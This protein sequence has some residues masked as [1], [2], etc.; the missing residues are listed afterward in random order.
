MYIVA[1][2]HLDIFRFV[3]ICVLECD[4]FNPN[5]NSFFTIR[6]QLISMNIIFP[7][8]D[9]THLKHFFPLN[10]HSMIMVKPMEDVWF[11]GHWVFC[12][13]DKCSMMGGCLM[14]GL[15]TLIKQK[16]KSFQLVKKK[17]I[18]R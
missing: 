11:I 13:L 18:F 6:K 9:Q 8:H 2:K 5:T 7:I 17:S 16:M 14:I 12:S 3:N 1:C 15:L 10:V 4:N